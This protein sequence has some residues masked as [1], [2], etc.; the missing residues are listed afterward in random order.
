M[1]ALILFLIPCLSLAAPGQISTRVGSSSSTGRANIDF[2]GRV[3][4]TN[5]FTTTFLMKSPTFLDNSI[6]IRAAATR[7]KNDYSNY[8]LRDRFGRETFLSKSFNTDEKNLDSGLD[9]TRG[10]HLA[11]FTHSRSVGATPFPYH[12]NTISYALSLWNGASQAGAA[13][14]SSR[15][16]QPANFYIDPRNF[17]NR[18]RARSLTSQ[19]EELFY[20]QTI[21]EK[22]KSRATLF[23]GNRFE[24]RPTHLG[25]ELRLAYALL[26]N[27]ALRLDSGLLRE[28]RKEVLRDDRGYFSARWAELQVGYEPALDLV[29]TVA[30]GTTIE[31]EDTPWDNIRRQVGSDS[32]GTKL[33]YRRGSWLANLAANSSITNT[34]YR[35]RSFSGEFTWEL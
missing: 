10:A 21:T 19:R 13:F 26:D 29:V 34:S 30:L 7:A 9:F 16:E 18:E 28:S 15:Q 17:R 4:N 20:E 11:S 25:G 12:S 32:F 35:N 5:A 33:S 31:H 6:V 23:H 2:V 24:D 14:S 3:E 27:L 22:F 1:R 8:I